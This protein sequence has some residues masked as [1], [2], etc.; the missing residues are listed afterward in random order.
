MSGQRFDELTKSVAAGSSSR[1]SFLKGL[2]AA[3]AGTTY[4]LTAP[5]NARAH[6]EGG[7]LCR[8]NGA[9]CR[10]NADCCS[11]YCDSFT[12]QCTCPPALP[13]CNAHGDC[14]DIGENCRANADCC[15]GL[16]V[17]ETFECACPP[18]LPNCN[19]HGDCRD[20]GAN[21]RSSAEC[22]SGFCDTSGHCAACPPGTELCRGNCIPAC[23]QCQECSQLTGMCAPKS[24]GTPCNDGNPCTVGD[25]CQNGVCAPGPLKNCDDGDPCTTDTCDPS[26]GMCQH[27]PLQGC[28]RC[29]NATQC[30]KPSNPCQQAT[31]TGGVCGVAIRP[32]GTSCSDGNTCTSGDTCQNGV[33]LGTPV[34]CALPQV[35]C[36]TGTFAGQCKLPSGAPCTAKAQCCSN[37]CPGTLRCA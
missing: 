27:T 3:A 23:N 24:N 9:L 28:T 32:N 37:N 21:C 22:C 26:T 1:R 36:A 29:T 7:E 11:R 31:C 4:G 17:T 30:P 15:L 13:D 2:V 16:C 18:Q 20:P 35:C 5:G 14:R 19:A 33:C 25:T 8:D 12:S 6:H 34:I 10:S